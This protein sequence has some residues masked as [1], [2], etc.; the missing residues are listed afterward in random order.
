MEFR[1]LHTI[2]AADN[3]PVRVELAGLAS[4]VFAFGIDFIVMIV[5]LCVF[6][7]AVFIPSW[8]R[9][10]PE[11]QKTVAPLGVFL[12]FFGYHLFQEWLW[13]GRSVGKLILGIRVVRQDGQPIGFWEALGR[14]LL[15]VVDVYVSGVGL[16]CMLF[17]AQEKRFGDFLAGT[18]VIR[19]D[20]VV[21][22]VYRSPLQ[23]QSGQ[24]DFL[25]VRILSA[26]E[27]ELLNAF[28]ARRKGLLKAERERLA[29]DLAFYFQQRLQEQIETETDLERLLAQLQAGGQ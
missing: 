18:L 17:N 26:E 5:L 25:A 19:N 27:I 29:G 9:Q 12:I 22:A 1:S 10:V 2:T 20:A 11:L 7:L 4:R 3:V 16:I 15:R 6:L 14:N 24:E 23:E 28:M 8:L 13:N 21:R